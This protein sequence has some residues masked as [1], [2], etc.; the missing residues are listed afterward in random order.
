MKKLLCL[1]LLCL[2]P[3][4]T[5]ATPTI[6][7][8]S[9]VTHGASVTISSGASD[10]TSKPTANPVAWDNLEDGVCDTT[11]TVGTWSTT[12]DLQT[13]D[14]TTNNQR[15]SNS[16]YAVDYNFTD[17][18]VDNNAAFTGGADSQAWYG[19][20]WFYFPTGTDF[21][22]HIA[23][24]TKFLRLWSTSGVPME[25]IRVTFEGYDVS[26]AIEDISGGTSIDW[27]P[28]I[29]GTNWVDEIF[30][31]PDPGFVDPG[32]MGWGEFETDL[33][34][35]VWHQVQMEYVDSTPG[36]ADGRI[37]IWIDGKL[38]LSR[39]AYQTR[40]SGETYFKRWKYLGFEETYG[41]TSDGNEHVFFDDYYI[42]NTLARVEIGNN[43]D[44]ALCTIKEIQPPTA[45]STS[46][47][48]VTG[49]VGSLTGTAYVFVIDVDGVVNETGFEITI[50]EASTN[51]AVVLEADKE[52]TSPATYTGIATAEAG[53]TITGVVSSNA[54]TV[55]PDDG[56]WDEQIESFTVSG[57]LPTVTDTCTA[58]DSSVETG[59]DSI[60]VTL[61]TAAT[62]ISASSVDL[63]SAIL[64]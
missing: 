56:T 27:E 61:P 32:K 20:Y 1:I 63:N 19:Q 42:D 44:Y 41:G 37:Q 60:T 38:I 46:S 28:V 36:V 59:L 2:I 34:G 5:L 3:C 13:D 35:Q 51:P 48:T 22:G 31:H 4:N 58:T 53:R 26:T 24:N 33:A 30:D 40:D 25:N 55:T 10:F 18:L 54:Y 29:T 7:S 23:N 9:S 57:V 12:N 47:I 6:N 52:S 49:N 11:A 15:N 17:D 8:V 45:W 43:A 16:T 50:G 21:A 39:T 62:G 14:I 64:K